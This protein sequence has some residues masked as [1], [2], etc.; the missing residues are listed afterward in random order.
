MIGLTQLRQ[1]NRML[2][3]GIV[4]RPMITLAI[5]IGYLFVLTKIKI[6]VIILK[7]SQAFKQIA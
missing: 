3:N 7:I 5:R 4:S 6:F 2:I 1:I